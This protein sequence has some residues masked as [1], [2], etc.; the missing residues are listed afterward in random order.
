MHL[1]GFLLLI[2][3]LL[4]V[5]AAEAAFPG[6]NGRIAFTREDSGEEGVSVLHRESRRFRGERVVSG[7]VFLQP[8]L[9]A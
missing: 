8:G 2:A 1:V 3:L 9:A 5:S 6:K 4:P 7:I